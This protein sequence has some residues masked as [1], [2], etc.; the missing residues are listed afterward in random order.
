MSTDLF[1]TLVTD[2]VGVVARV[3]VA[4]R[5]VDSLVAVGRRL[6]WDLDA[7]LAPITAL[8]AQARTVVQSFGD[9]VVTGTE[10][11]WLALADA[12]TG[13]HDAIVALESASFGAELDAAG[14]ANEFPVQL[15]HWAVLEHLNRAR[16]SL[17]GA[18]QALGFITTV[19]RPAAGIRPAYA[20]TRF[21]LPDLGELL[22][23]PSTWLRA[24]WAWGDPSFQGDAMLDRLAELFEQLGIA[25][26]FARM[27]PS[28][29]EDPAPPPG[30]LRHHLLARLVRGF[31]TSGEVELGIE[32]A[33]YEHSGGP[34]L[35]IVPYAVGGVDVGV[36][37]G[38]LNLVVS[39]M[40]SGGERGLRVRP[41]GIEVADDPLATEG[42]P[43]QGALTFTLSKAVGPPES[44]SDGPVQATTSGWQLTAGGKDDS[45]GGSELWIELRLPNLTLGLPA[46]DSGFVGSAVGAAPST[47][48]TP[49]TV[50]L[51]STRGLYLGATGL[52]FNRAVSLRLGALEVQRVSLALSGAERGLAAEMRT[53]LAVRLGPFTLTA[54]GLGVGLTLSFPES[55]GNVGP[56]DLAAE[57][58][59]PTGFGVA[60]DSAV[61]RGAGQIA[62][63]GPSEYRGA[64]ALDVMGVKVSGFGILDDAPGRAS[65]VAAIS[66]AFSPIPLGLGFTLE[67]VGGLIGIHRRVDTEALRAALRGPGIGD[68]FFGADPATQASRVLTDLARYFPA[69]PG[70]HV[71]GPA[72]KLGWG[73]PTIVEATVALLLEVPAPVR[74][75]LLGHAAIALPT[76][77][78]PVLE[79]NVDVLG[80]LDLARKT[81]AI[82]ATLRD[83]QVAGFPITGDL[84]L[85]MGWGDPPSFVLSV[86]GFHSQFRPPP[87][88]PELRRV[89]IPIGSGENPR[90]DITGFL[91]LTSNT[92]QIGAAVDLYAAAGPLN[93][94]GNLGF[95]ALIQFV[96]F[97]F[98][99]DLWAGVALRRGTRVLAG[100]HLDGKLRGPTPWRFSGEAC[101]SL[102]FIDL[103]VGFDAT[104]GQERAVALPTREIWPALE[105]ALEDHR[106]WGSTMPAS[107]A[108]AVTTAPPRD[109]LPATPGESAATR[110]DPVATLSVQQKVVPLNRVIERFAQVAPQGPNRFDVTAARLGASA[111]TPAPLEDWFAPAQFED[112]TDD[113]KLAR[114]GYEKMVAG[115]SLAGGAV[116]TVG[117]TLVKPLAYETIKFPDQEPLAAP[118]RPGRDQQLAGLATGSNGQA[119]LRPPRAVTPLVTLSEETFVIASALDL[120][121]RLDLAPP[122]G[123]TNAEL[124]LKAYLASHPESRGALQVVPRHEV[125]E[126]MP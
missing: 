80:E 2:A 107:G 83:S 7:T 110:I 85:R 35:A 48:P 125:Q 10:G 8:G 20:D 19:E 78:A 50:G 47:V 116:V 54:D 64:L 93:V 61:A 31:S 49:V 6:G 106:N 76:K 88:F 94:V 11:D 73:T 40:A 33:A 102:W 44:V 22:E 115:V 118:Y 108:R 89:H 111:L 15:L 46:A 90:L 96:P 72:A 37:F 66:A 57:V 55:G 112:L 12:I 126:L 113:E 43:V 9:L 1:R 16:P 77:D 114:P 17:A 95:E 52:T 42:A 58:L 84:A 32:F 26:G 29:A 53:A 81:L 60:I 98:E 67:G 13:V 45:S 3:A 99:V 100:V 25:A 82:D 86:G 23:S 34:V 21:T 75:V 51:S 121:P 5:D 71:F 69:A 56:I 91:A 59:T 105:E 92:A 124:A 63:F 30:A 122:A 104:F 79:L 65:L 101:L 41:T 97:G 109:E 14:F 39:G 70:R 24:V 120:T 62:R 119:P 68:I 38:G 103:C 117:P 87:G 74:L 27:P 4:G 123:R 28:S 18:L 36:T